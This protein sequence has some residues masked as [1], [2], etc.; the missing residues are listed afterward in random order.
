MPSDLTIIMYCDESTE[1]LYRLV[2]SLGGNVSDKQNRNQI[3]NELE[4][5]AEK[6]AAQ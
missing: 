2:R 4:R 5:L 1:N 3:L 6:A